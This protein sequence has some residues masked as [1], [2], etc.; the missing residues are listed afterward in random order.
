MND[1]PSNPDEPDDIGDRYRRASALDTSRPSERV[2]NAV[3]G[4]AARLAAQRGA[5]K[6]TARIEFER[7]AQ[8][9]AWRRRRPAIVGTLAAA[10]LAGLLVTPYLI[11]PGAPDRSAIRPAPS[12]APVEA[13][14]KPRA[15]ALPMRA[16]DMAKESPNAASKASGDVA[17]QRADRAQGGAQASF[18]AQNQRP[19]SP[20][21]TAA[22]GAPAPNSPAARDADLGP[23]LRQAAETGDIPRLRA[24]LEV[25]G[26]IDARDAAGRTALMVATL[27]R[28]ATAVDLLLAHGADPN[29]ADAQG[30]TALQAAEADD[31]R[32]IV[33]ALRRAGAK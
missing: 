28:Q 2:R 9:R 3:L 18:A 22:R 27:H 32:A 11:G 30:R 17:Q 29:A 8:D 16:Q 15:P 5:N 21:F 13:A 20:G 33:A 24:L 14:S 23:D 25:G 26:D 6:Q 7:Y 1:R 10:V 12:A 4:H 31:Q 19:V